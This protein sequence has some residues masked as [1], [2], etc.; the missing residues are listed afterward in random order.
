MCPGFLRFAPNRAIA[1]VSK[2][3]GSQNGRV[4]GAFVR[5][6]FINAAAVASGSFA[7]LVLALRI[8][9]LCDGEEQPETQFLGLKIAGNEIGAILQPP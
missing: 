6:M 5:R 9:Q 1:S 2:G 4:T 3:C 8:L 7:N